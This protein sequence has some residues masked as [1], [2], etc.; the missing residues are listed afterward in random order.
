MLGFLNR[1]RR[2]RSGFR[3]GGIRGAALAGVGMLAW[4]WWKNRKGSEA[5][6]N[7]HRDRSFSESGSSHSAG[8]Y[9]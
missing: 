5:T 4:R 9:S 6:S 2:S 7:Q 1:T 8:Q 3:P